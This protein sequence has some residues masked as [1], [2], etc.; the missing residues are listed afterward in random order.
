[1][2]TGNQV[3]AHT[4][5]VSPEPE[6]G[7]WLVPGTRLPV[8]R[9]RMVF[10]MHG[11]LRLPDFAGSLLRGQ[12]GAALRRSACMTGAPACGPCPLR[13]TCPFPQIFDTPPPSHHRLQRFSQVPNPYVI[14]PPPIGTRSIDA[15]ACLSFS[16]VLVGRARERFPLVLYAFQRAFER[17]LSDARVS[18]SLEQVDLDGPEGWV[19]VFDAVRGRVREHD[20]TLEVPA[21]PAVERLTLDLC[22]P[23][24]LQR[25]GHPLPPAELKPRDLIV[26][27]LRRAL[28]L[29]ELH[30]DLRLPDSD[31]YAVSVASDGGALAGEGSLRWHDWTRYSSRQRQEMTL[32]GALGT[33]TFQGAMGRVLPL[34][35]LGQW[36]HVG[37]NATMG[38]GAYTL[39]WREASTSDA[40]TIT[41]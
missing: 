18:G 40:R 36:L 24:R 23:L 25:N 15:G 7:A 20:A 19:D 8:V 41:A 13:Q 37:K 14:E 29:L 34:L 6:P 21:L 26:A 39:R 30:A 32:G 16:V 17:G 31:A 28:L 3:S 27:L 2:G 12:F 10:R 4:Q 1:M 5:R 22:T 33:W 38:M 11:A 9:Y 35:W